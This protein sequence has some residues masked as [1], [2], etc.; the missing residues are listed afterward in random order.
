MLVKSHADCAKVLKLADLRNDSMKTVIILLSTMVL[1]SCNQYQETDCRAIAI[2]ATEE[3]GQDR[4]NAYAAL[5]YH[6]G[7]LAKRLK[8]IGRG[9]SKSYEKAYTQCRQIETGR[10]PRLNIDIPPQIK[11]T[12]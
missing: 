12:R 4:D 6:E 5:P 8:G 11:V 3:K 7:M 1:A 2:A 9:G 10:P